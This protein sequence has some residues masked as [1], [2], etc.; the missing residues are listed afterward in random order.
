[1]ETDGVKQPFFL[2]IVVPYL[3]WLRLASTSIALAVFVWS[4]VRFIFDALY[5]PITVTGILIITILFYYIGN[6]LRD[7]KRLAVYALCALCILSYA[8]AIYGRANVN[9][10]G[11]VS[12]LIWLMAIIDVPLLIGIFIHWKHFK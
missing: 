2:R 1:M 9:N 11:F 8:A 10:F 5:W 3:L 12:S 7:R 4:L 6:G